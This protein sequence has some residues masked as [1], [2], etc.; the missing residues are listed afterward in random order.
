VLVGCI[1][2]KCDLLLHV[3]SPLRNQYAKAEWGQ[4][5]WG[6]L[7]SSGCC[8]HDS[9]F[10]REPMSIAHLP[11]E[12]TSGNGAVALRFHVERLKARRLEKGSAFCYTLDVI[13]PARVSAGRWTVK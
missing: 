7:D 11:N 1:P 3:V 5:G 4:S 8:S 6:I 12:R 2:P 9:I 10:E 13:G